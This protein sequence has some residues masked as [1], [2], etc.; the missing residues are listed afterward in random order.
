[1]P[2]LRE[3]IVRRLIVSKD[4]LTTSTPLRPDSDPVVVA[5]TILSAHDAAE[6]ALAAIADQ[7]GVQ[8]SKDKL[9]L[10]DYPIRIATH[11]N[12]G[13]AFPGSSFLKQLNIARNAFKHGGVLPDPRQM[14]TVSDRTL[15]LV[16][17]ACQHYIGI[18]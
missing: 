12:D 14:Y 2:D 17:E 4:L 1:M 11:V 13:H 9:F 18:A 16:N 6:L 3:D 15:D 8:G 10:M 5:K 7:V